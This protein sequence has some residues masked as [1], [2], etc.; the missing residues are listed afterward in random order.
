M[1]ASTITP[2]TNP[3]VV[4]S[5]S[6]AFI[7]R[8][9]PDVSTL[10]SALDR[11]TDIYELDP[12]QDAVAQITA[13]LAEYQNLE[14][15]SIFSHGSSGSLAL[16]LNHDNIEAHAD[17]LGT[18]Q[19]ALAPAADLLLYACEVGLGETGQN[20]INRLSQL[21][22]ADTA[23]ASN[24]IGNT[25]TG[26]NW[27]LDVNSGNIRTFPLDVSQLSAYKGTLTTVGKLDPTF[28]NNGGKLIADFGGGESGEGLVIQPDGKIIVTGFTASAGETPANTIVVLRYN[29]DGTL[30]TT[31]GGDGGI[32]TNL[33]TVT[34]EVAHAAVVQSDGKIVVAGHS[35][36]NFNVIRY[37]PDGTLDSTFGTGGIV[38]TDLGTSVDS[39]ESITLQA[40]GKILLGGFSGNAYAL[41]RYNTNGTL[42][43]TFNTSGAI[44]TP[45]ATGNADGQSVKVQA[46]GKILMGGSVNGDFG[47]VRYNANGTQDTTFG[48]GGTVATD[49]SGGSDV[50]ESVTIQSDGKILLSGYRNIGTGETATGQDFVV[51]RYN[52]DG[53]LDNTFG[54]AGKLISDFGGFD[55]TESIALQ[56]DGKFII[57][58]AIDADFGLA[59]YNANGTLD[60]TFGNGGKFVTDFFNSSLEI[61]RSLAVQADG[62][63]VMTGSS[64]G[65]IALARYN[66]TNIIANESDFGGN[67]KADILWRNTDG[68]LAIWQMNGLTSTQSLVPNPSTAWSISDTADFNND[69]FADILWRNT[70][71]SVATWLMDGDTLTSSAIVGNPG[72][73]WSI[74]NTGDFN[75]DAKSDI[76]WR[77]DTGEVAVWQMNGNTLQASAIVDTVDKSWQ[78]SDVIDFDSDGKSDL[79]WRKDNGEVGIWKMDGSSYQYTNLGNP[80]TEWKIADTDDLNGDNKGDIVWRKDNGDVAVWL[81]D[82]ARIASAAVVGNVATD[83]KIKD[84]GDFNGD[85][86]ADLIWRRDS[87]GA[88]AYW[89]MNG[90]SLTSS[91]I[92][93]TP[94][95]AWNIT[96][97][98]DLNGDNKSDILWRNTSGEAAGWLMNGG[99]ITSS[100]SL[101][102]PGTAWQVS[103]PIST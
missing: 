91:N 78:V 88:A 102:N 28:G 50:G 29:P 83:W 26:D 61:G 101:G 74:V 5:K 7:D 73:A 2:I 19:S 8:S 85:G 34:D 96:G 46:D 31:F 41:A 103:A 72:T 14:T 11:H 55:N 70:D 67:G 90:L 32:G 42:D 38:T 58:G 21:T 63:V 30:D 23:A 54:T 51:V 62:K 9:V 52:T 43:T 95:T 6:I 4:T 98:S 18:W 49:I 12:Q 37:N 66:P 65:D 33:D 17:A 57:G 71:G 25:P 48:T 68:R 35:N 97:T 44:I 64:N 16:G 100:A 3:N 45:P 94:G 40:D 79:L 89:Q 76:L 77:K 1:P 27:V 84:T 22:G 24:L 39:A 10:R 56:A 80:G 99:T 81:M 60:P 53:T 15:I 36:G 93:G 13:Q 86:N 82:G 87:D 59:R 47:L 69:N 92:I 20:F 75:A